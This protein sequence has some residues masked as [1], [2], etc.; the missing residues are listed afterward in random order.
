MFF[1]RSRPFQWYHLAPNGD[2]ELAI[3]SLY[4][5]YK[6]EKICI[7][8]YVCWWSSTYRYWDIGR[9]NDDQKRSPLI[10]I[11]PDSK[12]HGANM[13]PIWGG[14]DPGRP[15]DGPMNLAIRVDININIDADTDLDWSKYIHI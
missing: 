12:V 7:Q 14:E 8:H 13:A 1:F 11:Y 3:A 6:H 15:H 5:S 9:Y 2:S 4:I 10:D